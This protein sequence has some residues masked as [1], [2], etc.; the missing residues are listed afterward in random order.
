MLERWPTLTTDPAGD[1]RIFKIRSETKQSPRTGKSHQFYILDA[2]D[3]VN[4]IPVTPDGQMVLVEQYR[5]GTD[6][7]EL[8][9]PGGM[10][11]A[12]DGSPE[13]TAIR[14][15]REET[16]YEGESAQI[17]GSVRP[18]PA[19]MTN[20]CYAVLVENCKLKHDTAFDHGEDLV[21]RLVDIDQIPEL[22]A[23]GKIQHSIV[24]ASLYHFHLWRRGNR[25]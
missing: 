23:S 9:I 25:G 13:A 2:V 8:E 6:S 4:I 16:G 3:W 11:D 12:E 18:N 1:F 17:I 22:V 14:E 15:L 10:I 19:F 20:T 21:N 7:I 24:V 5:H